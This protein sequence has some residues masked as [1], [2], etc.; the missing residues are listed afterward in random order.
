MAESIISGKGI[1]L[2]CC[3]VNSDGR[4]LVP[5]QL[6]EN[7]K[8][9]DFCNHKTEEWIWSIGKRRSDGVILASHGSELYQNPEFECL[10]LR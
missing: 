1:S 2:A 9:G 6:F 10:W 8:D 7:S 5:K 3:E 4:Y